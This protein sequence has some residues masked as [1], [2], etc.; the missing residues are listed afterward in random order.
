MKDLKKLQ[1]GNTD[2][3]ASGETYHECRHKDWESEVDKK[4]FDSIPKRTASSWNIQSSDCV[5]KRSSI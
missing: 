4:F 2:V 5:F 1:K 3:I